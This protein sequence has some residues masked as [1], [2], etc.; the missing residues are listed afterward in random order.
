MSFRNPS[1][2]EIESLLR[3]ARTIAVVGLSADASR[4]SHGVAA[5]MQRFG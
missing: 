1:P 4:A 5:A 3:G 2:A